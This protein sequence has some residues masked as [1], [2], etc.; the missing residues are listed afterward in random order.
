[1]TRCVGHRGAAGLAPENSLAAFRAGIAAG[2]DAVECD[3]H[4]T[5]DGYLVLMHDAD[6]NRTTDGTGQIGAMLLADLQHLNCAAKFGDGVSAPQHVPRLEDLLD[7]A[8]GQC[9]VQVEIKVPRPRAYAGIELQVVTALREHTMIDGAQVICF[10]AQTLA[11]VHAIEPRLALGFLGS[12]SSLPAF[13]RSDAVALVAH[14][15]GCG[16]GF[17]GLDRE[18]VRAEHLRAARARGLALGVWTVNDALEMES[19]IDWGV[20]AVTSDRPDILR[21]VLDDSAR[22]H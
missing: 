17:L 14:A 20:D 16:A 6:V 11:R 5:R 3:V 13:L 1:M 21:R 7:L 12:A 8:A 18:Y 22:T 19:L 9:A 15:E 4:Q 2:A 10:D